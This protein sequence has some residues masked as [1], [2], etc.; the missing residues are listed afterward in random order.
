LK[1]IAGK[2]QQPF[3]NQ[4][5]EVLEYFVVQRQILRGVFKEWKVWGFANEWDMETIAEDK[6]A[7][8]D[9]NAAQA[10]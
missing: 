5:G 3:F 7:E 9:M 4:P 10:A 8:R 2:G 1:Y 6:Q